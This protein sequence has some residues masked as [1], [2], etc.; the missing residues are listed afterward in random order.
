MDSAH[1]ISR[2]SHD[3]FDR[4]FWGI[5]EKNYA[6]ACL[7]ALAHLLIWINEVFDPQTLILT[8][9]LMLF[10]H[11]L[12]QNKKWAKLAIHAFRNS[13]CKFNMLTLIVPNRNI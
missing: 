10:Y 12:W 6:L 9:K 5:T 4:R 1:R 7:I 2:S 11:S 3:L 13:A 8:K